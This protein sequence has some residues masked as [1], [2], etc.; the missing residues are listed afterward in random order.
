MCTAVLR[1]TRI[2][3]PGATVSEW[4]TSGYG[5]QSQEPTPNSK[6]PLFHE[7][8]ECS[9]VFGP[10]LQSAGEDSVLRQKRVHPRSCRTNSD[11]EQGDQSEIPDPTADEQEE[12]ARL[13]CPSPV[14]SC[15]QASRFYGGG[16]PRPVPPLQADPG[17]SSSW[18]LQGG[19]LEIDGSMHRFLWPFDLGA[20][21]LHGPNATRSLNGSSDNDDE[22]VD[23]IFSPHPGRSNEV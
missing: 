3:S 20:A 21:L 11:P 6:L 12:C 18:E 5:S 1:H 16:T 14:P 19:M 17:C 22:S 4:E 10:P 8:D 23:L 2:A 13:Q 9:T 7:A 15:P